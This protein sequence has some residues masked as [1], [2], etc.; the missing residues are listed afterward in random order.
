MTKNFV[1]IYHKLVVD[2][3]T[4]R[5]F[6]YLLCYGVDFVTEATYYDMFLVLTIFFRYMFRRKSK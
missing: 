4:L 5:S 1:L 6:M 3:L 2:F